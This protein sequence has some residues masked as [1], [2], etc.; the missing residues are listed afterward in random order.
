MLVRSAEVGK[1][2]AREI[3]DVDLRLVA[4]Q[5]V[6]ATQRVVTAVLLIAPVLRRRPL[7]ARVKAARET[8]LRTHPG[9]F[10]GH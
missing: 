2:D 9:S 3:L 6:P 8:P 7:Q 5:R 10:S 4:A 1:R